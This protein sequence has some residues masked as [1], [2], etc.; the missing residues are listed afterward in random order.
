MKKKFTLIELLVVIAIIAILAS[1]LLPALSKARASAQS[2]KCVSNL[3]Q[4][5]LGSAMYAGDEK[6]TLPPAVFHVGFPWWTSLTPYVAGGT[7]DT[8]QNFLNVRSKVFTCPTIVGNDGGYYGLNDSVVNY[9]YSGRCG[10]QSYNTPG[11]WVQLSSVKSPSEKMQITD[12]SNRYD[13]GTNTDGSPRIMY[14]FSH[15]DITADT[16]RSILPEQVHNKF[17][18]SVFLDGHAAGIQH[19]DVLNKN[20]DIR[21]DGI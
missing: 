21:D 7:G 15:F 19:K 5:G 6:D 14:Y 10:W 9:S 13:D 17:I 3:K 2:I 4:L 18:N 8:E 11:T 1:M 16:S 12:G 20:I